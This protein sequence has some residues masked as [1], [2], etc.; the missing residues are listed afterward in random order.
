MFPERGLRFAFA[1][2]SPAVDRTEPTQ[3]GPFV[4]GKADKAYARS[5]CYDISSNQATIAVRSRSVHREGAPRVAADKAFKRVEEIFS[6][7]NGRLHCVA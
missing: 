6:T 4:G 3:T 1:L 7:L 2:Q 5:T